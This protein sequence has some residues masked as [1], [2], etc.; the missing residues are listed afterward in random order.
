[1]A[2]PKKKPE[3]KLKVGCKSIYNQ[4]IADL[5]CMR[6]ATNTLGLSRMCEKY[7]DLPD[8]S[9][10]NEWRFKHPEFASQYAK[11][12]LV[13]ADLLAEETLEIA[14]DA[15][16]DWM[17]S[18]GE[19]GDVLYKINGEHVARSR[20]RI[21]TRKFLAA[22]LLPKQYGDAAR[23][24]NNNKSPVLVVYNDKKKE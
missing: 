6:V 11:A 14:D 15:T 21:D 10:I 20:L 18:F 1:M 22:K 17:E 16:N 24:D 12:K 4:E 5:I 3:D 9:T 19:N 7:A 23:D 13:Q 2:T 8:K